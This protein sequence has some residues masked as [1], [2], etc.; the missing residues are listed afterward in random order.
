MAAS[1]SAVE[2]DCPQH[3]QPTGSSAIPSRRSVNLH[4]GTV[5]RPKRLDILPAPEESVVLLSTGRFGA[6]FRK[7]PD[8]TR[9]SPPW[10]IVD[11]AAQ[12]Q[13]EL[14]RDRLRRGLR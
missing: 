10:R 7:H 6:R 1:G 13:A 2:H 3:A 12:A 5:L 8:G 9:P 4:R 11:T 14:T